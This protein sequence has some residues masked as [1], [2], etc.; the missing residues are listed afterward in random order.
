MVNPTEALHDVGE[1]K[2]I[3]TTSTGGGFDCENTELLGANVYFSV[4]F[5]FVFTGCRKRRGSD[6]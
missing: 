3:E 2:I 6:Q 1:N 4:I 5:C